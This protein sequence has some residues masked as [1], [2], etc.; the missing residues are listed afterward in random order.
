MNLHKIIKQF[1]KV[2]YS[3]NPSTWLIP[4]NENFYLES[5]QL[6]ILT[7]RKENSG[8][9]WGGGGGIFQRE[10]TQRNRFTSTVI[11]LATFKERS[12]VDLDLLF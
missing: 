7:S 8:V 10:R 11:R 6:T 12:H 5:V 1:L 3:F 2:G 4:L 9:G